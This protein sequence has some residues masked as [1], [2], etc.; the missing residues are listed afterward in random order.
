MLPYVKL[1]SFALQPLQSCIDGEEI[2]ALLHE[3]R[4]YSDCERNRT[5]DTVKYIVKT[6]RHFSM[7]S[8]Y[9]IGESILSGKVVCVQVMIEGSVCSSDD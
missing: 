5:H 1:R 6:K 2:K 4:G 9:T 8:L 3:W 7:R